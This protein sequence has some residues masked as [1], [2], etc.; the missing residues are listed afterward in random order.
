MPGPEAAPSLASEALRAGRVGLG[1]SFRFHR[2]RGALCG[3]G[4]CSQCQVTTPTGRALACQE[5]PGLAVGARDPLRPLG[6]LAERWPPWFYERRFLRPAAAQRLHLDLLRRLTSAPRLGP[7][8]RTASVRAFCE[9]ETDVAIVGRNGNVDGTVLG[10]YDGRV[11]G[12]LRPDALV[13]LRF[14]RLVLVTGSYERLPPIPGNDLPGIVGVH[15]LERYAAAGAVRAGLRLALWG[16]AD[17]LVRARTLASAHG[18]EVVWESARAPRALLGRDRV[19]GLV[20]DGRVPCDLFVVAAAQPA[21]ELAL[22]AGARAE[23]TSGELPVLVARGAPA[24]LALEGAAAAR[25]SGIPDVP[26]NDAAFACLCEDVRVR[27]VRRAIAEGFGHPEL[28]KRRTG[29]LTGPCQG[30][31][32]APLVLALLREAGCPHEPTT[33]RPPARAVTLAELAAHA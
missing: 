13:A 7:A 23:L 30:K 9:E 17:R 20:D 29:A 11:L 14:E 15:A 21:L 27:D 16:D 28:V 1:R 18:A 12:V 8:A 19:R 6:R 33:A 22:Q 24:W 5:P 25:G 3:R 32:C 26:A 31:L 10:V 2:P 4:Y